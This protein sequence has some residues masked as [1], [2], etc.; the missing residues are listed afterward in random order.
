MTA[1]PFIPTLPLVWRDNRVFVTPAAG[2]PAH[3]LFCYLPSLGQAIP[4]QPDSTDL[5]QHIVSDEHFVS[6]RRGTIVSLG[7]LSEALAPHSLDATL[8]FLEFCRGWQ[9][10]FQLA[11]RWIVPSRFFDRFLGAAANLRLVLFHSMSTLTQASRFEP[12]TP[13]PDRRLAFLRQCS[14]SGLTNVIYVKPFLPGITLRD[15]DDFCEIASRHVIRAFVVGPIYLDDGISASL[16]R[17]VT[18]R[19]DPSLFALRRHPMDEV[20]TSTPPAKDSEAAI[21]VARLRE[22]GIPVYTH[23]TAPLPDI[24]AQ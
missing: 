13:A 9:N 4:R 10:P 11:T 17:H 5:A 22:R 20:I 24:L 21:F 2:C 23:S 7:C 19:R 12:G 3:C 8:A 18:I 1:A 16:A 6:G 15:V 14:E